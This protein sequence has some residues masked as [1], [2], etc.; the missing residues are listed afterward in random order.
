[1]AGLPCR[2]RW[3]ILS[4]LTEAG[5]RQVVQQLLALVPQPTALYCFNNT[6][7]RLVSEE[8]RRRGLQT[9][10]DLSVMGAGGEDVPGLTCHQIEWYQL[11]RAG[12]QI[13]LR[14]LTDP[15]DHPPEH[16][17]SAPVLRVGQ[18]TTAL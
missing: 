3:E 10:Q 4:E 11:G 17:L 12:V 1:D 2:R 13:L 5:A 15:D 7:A 6:L 9:P 8:L 18:T 14:A 16:H